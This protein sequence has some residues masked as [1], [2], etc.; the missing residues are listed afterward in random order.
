MGIEGPN[1][2]KPVQRFREL[3]EHRAS[4]SGLEALEHSEEMSN[5]EASEVVGRLVMRVAKEDGI[6]LDRIELNPP[7]G[8]HS[9]FL[10]KFFQQKKEKVNAY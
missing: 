7:I 9:I 10:E 3:G 1:G 5:G 4:C 8:S 6:G 2:Y